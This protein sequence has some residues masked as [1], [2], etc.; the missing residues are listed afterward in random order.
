MQQV[1]TSQTNLWVAAACSVGL[2]EWHAEVPA[3]LARAEQ[4]KVL[5]AHRRAHHVSLLASVL[6]LLHRQEVAQYD[7]PRSGSSSPR[8]GP[9]VLQQGSATNACLAAGAGV[10]V[11]LI[12]ASGAATRVV[13]SGGGQVQEGLEQGQT[14]PGELLLMQQQQQH[15]QV[16]VAAA[17]LDKASQEFDEDEFFMPVRLCEE[18][19]HHADKPVHGARR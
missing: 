10:V 1:V 12:A 18:R 5:L 7:R 2:Q 3:M 14:G 19:V 11:P 8:K 13:A 9:L 4:L 15:A 6:Q 16:L 17:G